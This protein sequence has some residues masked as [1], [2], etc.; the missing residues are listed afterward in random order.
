MQIGP[1]AIGLAIAVIPLTLLT[2][3]SFVGSQSGSRDSW[4]PPVLDE[5][6]RVQSS[7]AEELTK[8]GGDGVADVTDPIGFSLEGEPTGDLKLPFEL[9]KT[10]ASVE[11]ARQSDDLE[12]ANRA[13]GSL[14]GIIRNQL[15]AIEALPPNGREIA[16][17]LQQRLKTSERRSKWLENRESV[18]K[19]LAAAQKAIAAGPEIDGEEACLATIS[20]LKKRLPEVVSSEGIASEPGDALTLSEAKT[21]HELATRATFR[22]DFLRTRRDTASGALSASQLGDVVLAWDAF[23]KA[24]SS[25]G[26]PDQRDAEFIQQAEG[27]R[28]VA[29][30]K[31]LRTTAQEQ[32]TADGL[33]N[34][35]AVWLIEAA[36]VPAELER[37]RN[38]AAADVQKWLSRQVPELA[39][40]PAVGNGIQEG[41]TNTTRFVGFFEPVR[42]T[43]A[44][45]RWWDWNADAEARAAAP[46]GMKQFNLKEPPAAP[47]HKQFL[48][49]YAESRDAFLSREPEGFGSVQAI[50]RFRLASEKLKTEFEEYRATWMPPLTFPFDTA[51]E[52]WGQE[53][54]RAQQ[55]SQEFEDAAEK[56]S[57]PRLLEP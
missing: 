14:A 53:F 44:Q 3:A 23:L 31:L 52:N 1:T 21:A 48:T 26:A 36:H 42:G 50:Q 56:H 11:A 29:R 40:L 46:K 32:T 34:A 20:A 13:T 2:A 8:Q 12:A 55:V 7:A 25:A 51:A 17:D 5:Y 49:D 24:W 43:K 39:P 6:A 33:L 27:L 16:A 30:L 15:P 18:K 35:V 19:D 28:R 4:S 37:E 57:L 9:A 10:L 22:R 38:L 47:R 45:Y 41:F 54:D